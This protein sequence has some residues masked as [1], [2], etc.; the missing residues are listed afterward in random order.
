MRGSTATIKLLFPAIALVLI[1]GIFCGSSR[2]GM[3]QQKLAEPARRQNLPGGYAS[4]G[5]CGADPRVR[6]AAEFAVQR[7]Q[8]AS[9]SVSSSSS[10][11]GLPNFPTLLL[12]KK[13]ATT[14]TAQQRIASATLPFVVAR[15]YRQVVAGINYRLVIVLLS[16]RDG[17]D[18]ENDGIKRTEASEIAAERRNVLGGFG[19]TV[20]DHFGELSVTKWGNEISQEKAAALLKNDQEFGEDSTEDTFLF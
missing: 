14:S 12:T 10:S 7:L 20:Y 9:V 13:A 11:D 4:I 18:D 2:S 1:L 6:A 8:E 19:V 5:N 3:A 17:G 16:A 15:G